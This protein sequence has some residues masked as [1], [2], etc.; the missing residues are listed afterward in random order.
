MLALDMSDIKMVDADDGA[1]ITCDGMSETGDMGLA[2]GYTYTGNKKYDE[3]QEKEQRILLSGFQFFG[4]GAEPSPVV[5]EMDERK[6]SKA[7]RNGNVGAQPN[8]M[9]RLLAFQNAVQKL[10]GYGCKDDKDKQE[11]IYSVLG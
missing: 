9:S 8:N 5:L 4:Q 2:E 7:S 11:M 6:D 1:E 10:A 3:S